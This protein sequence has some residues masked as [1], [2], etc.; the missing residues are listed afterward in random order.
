MPETGVTLKN[1]LKQVAWLNKGAF[2]IRSVLPIHSNVL[3]RIHR[4]CNR[5]PEVAP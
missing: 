4:V 3:A 5:V 2:I 1:H